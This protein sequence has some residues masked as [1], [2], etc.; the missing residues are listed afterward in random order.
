M[1]SLFEIVLNSDQNLTL[2]GNKT[3]NIYNLWFRSLLDMSLI[4]HTSAISILKLSN[5]QVIA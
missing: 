4:Q 3:T 2:N 5:V 1:K